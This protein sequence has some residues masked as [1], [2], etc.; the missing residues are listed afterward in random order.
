MP[1][2]G[3]YHLYDDVEYTSQPTAARSTGACGVRWTP[4]TTTLA[5]TSWAAA[6]IA[7]MSGIVPIA[8]EAP[9]TA[10][11]R[12]RSLNKAVTAAVSSRPVVGVEV[13]HPHGRTRVGPDQQPRRDVRIVIEPR[14]HDLV[15]RTQLAADRPRDREHV[16]GGRRP[17]HESGWVGAEQ[18][19]HRGLGSFGERVA[20]LGRGERAVAVGVVAAALPVGGGVDRGVDDLG[21]RRPVEASPAV[22]QAGESVPHVNGDCRVRLA[23]HP[24]RRTP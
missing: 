11:H 7:V 6:V 1:A 2:C 8:F 5:P 10:T 24:C 3:P 13:G 19:A 18:L 4:S 9:V 20:R 14:A 22:R 17:E 23:G 12:V 16:V 15:A 21:A